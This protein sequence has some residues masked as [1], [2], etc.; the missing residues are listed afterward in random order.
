MGWS[1][2]TRSFHDTKSY[3]NH[4]L[5]ASEGEFVKLLGQYQF[6]ADFY[7]KK[8]S[9]VETNCCV[10]LLLFGWG[11]ILESGMSCL[12][13]IKICEKCSVAPQQFNFYTKKN[14]HAC[15]IQSTQIFSNTL[16]IGVTIF[17]DGLFCIVSVTIN[18]ASPMQF[19]IRLKAETPLSRRLWWVRKVLLIQ[20]MLEI[21]RNITRTGKQLT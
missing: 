7:S 1:F 17:D 4:S 8:P 19:Q 16:K 13:F 9:I 18:V 5:P 12:K 20:E 15:K 14:N 6:K 10:I 2:C 11:F 21:N 3:R